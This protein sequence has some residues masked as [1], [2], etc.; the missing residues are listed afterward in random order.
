MIVNESIICMPLTTWDSDLPNTLVQLMQIISKDNTVLFVDYQYSIKDLIKINSTKR[1]PPVKRVLGFEKR[2]RKVTTKKGGEIYVLTPPPVLPINRVKNK[3]LYMALIQINGFI[4]KGTIK[5][6]AKTIGIKNPIVING[7]NPF[8]GL[9]LAGSFNEFLNVY[10]CYDE[11]KG[12]KFYNL[13]GP[14]IEELYMKK[15]DAIIATSDALKSSKSVNGKC[16]VIKNGVDFDLL[17]SVANYPKNK[18][19]PLVVGY[20]GSIDE[21]FDTD[22]VSYAITNLPD[23]Q[24]QFLGRIT[25][26]LAKTA[27][28]K[29]SNVVFLGGRTPEEVPDA[30]K[31][32]DVCIIP[33]I[34]NEVT[35]NVYP[36]KIN[37]YLAAGKP[38]IMTNFA[39]IKE[40]ETVIKIATSKEEF[41]EFVKE[42]LYSDSEDRKKNRIAFAALNSWNA[43]AEELSNIIKELKS[44]KILG[45]K[46]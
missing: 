36:L 38:V 3:R 33:Y 9:P 31:E 25:N 37:E 12:D 10:Y 2:L 1:K 45:I 26:P 44:E 23:V 11:I 32:M 22:T 17:N 41:L 14:A 4:I 29:F 27:L 16:Y 34:K 13:Y 6:A 19:L 43:K 28:E 20:S 24:F 18:T 30:L 5:R 7:Y 21:R 15:T 8:A 42:E 39:E 46:N 40:L 35:K